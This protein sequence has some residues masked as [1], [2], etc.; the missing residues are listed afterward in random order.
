MDFRKLFTSILSAYTTSM[1]KI[2]LLINRQHKYKMNRL[3][4]HLNHSQF[5]LYLSD[6]GQIYNARRVG[7]KCGSGY[8]TERTC[9]TDMRIKCGTD[10]GIKCGTDMGIKCGTDMGI[11]CGT[12]L[13]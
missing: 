12:L 3:R 4:S 1:L 8:G 11:K 9:G 13:F 7:L 2:L 10:M 5:V 6:H